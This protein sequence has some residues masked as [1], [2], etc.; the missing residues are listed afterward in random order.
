MERKKKVRL[1]DIAEKLNVSTVTV[2]KAL[3][4]PLVGKVSAND[5]WEKVVNTYNKTG[6]FFNKIGN[7][8]GKDDEMKDD[9]TSDLTQYTT[10]KALEAIF[11]K[12]AEE[13]GKIRANP[14]LTTSDNIKKVFGSR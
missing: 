10:E 9:V 1:S 4:E 3:S 14:R 5:A 13:E 7:I 11:L 2:S 12:M 6:S 8:F